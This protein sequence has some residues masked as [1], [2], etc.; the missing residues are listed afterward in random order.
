MTPSSSGVVLLRE[1]EHVEAVQQLVPSGVYPLFVLVTY[2]GS[3]GTL[4]IGLAL[5]HW[6]WDRDRTA[7]VIGVM[8]GGIAV[9]IG[10]KAVFALPRPPPSYW[11]VPTEG[12]GFPSGHAIVATVVYGSIAVLAVE[13]RR[14]WRIV[15]S[16][17]LISLVGVSR[18][19]L[20]VHYPIDVVTGTAIGLLYLGVVVVLSGG[21]PHRSFR[22]ATIAAGAALVLST[23]NPA[24]VGI[25]GGTVGSTLTWQIRENGVVSEPRRGRF[26]SAAPGVPIVVVLGYTLLLTP[27]SPL[28]LLVL[29]SLTGGVVFGLPVVV[30]S[31][32]SK[33]GS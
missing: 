25:L 1:I 27:R 6:L 19:V 10:L 32:T 24:S 23:A 3:P 12:L 5:A 16:G 13:S 20:G 21:D 4:L 7:F 18:V 14:G 28:V 30:A 11:I 22:V 9:T 2:L 8:L 26:L 17:T 15:A 33:I 31:L 29:S